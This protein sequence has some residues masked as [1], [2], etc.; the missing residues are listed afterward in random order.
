MGY[1]I[2][3]SLGRCK[4]DN[5]SSLKELIMDKGRNLNC[6]NV[7]YFHDVDK[8]KKKIIHYNI[9]CA[10]FDNSKIENLALYINFLKKLRGVH[11]ESIYED[12]VVYRL[13]YASP[14]YLKKMDKEFVKIF[15]LNNKKNVCAIKGM[16]KNEN[17]TNK[18]ERSYS[19]SDYLVLSSILNLNKP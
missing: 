19:D 16:E 6:E 14:Q 3:I 17:K 10:S 7:Y 2:E 18:R 13:I 9:I 5:L 15:K 4:C 12:D 8:V 11:I 1:S